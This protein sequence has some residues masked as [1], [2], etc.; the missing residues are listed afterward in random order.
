MARNGCAGG[1]PFV[2]YGPAPDPG[3]RFSSAAPGDIRQDPLRKLWEGDMD[4]SQQ[5][6]CLKK[7]T[8]IEQVQ[9]FSS[10]QNVLAEVH[11]SELE[12]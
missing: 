9:G 6:S 4:A 8:E 11:H 5:T 2:H 12:K 3:H 10:I 1:V 7:A